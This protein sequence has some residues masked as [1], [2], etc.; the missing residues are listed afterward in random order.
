M[1]LVKIAI[2]EITLQESVNE[3]GKTV[4]HYSL[5][6]LKISLYDDSLAPL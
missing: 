3:T 1:S 5:M 2:A 4:A 6:F